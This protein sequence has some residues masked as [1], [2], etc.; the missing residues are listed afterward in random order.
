MPKKIIIFFCVSAVFLIFTALGLI[1]Y[2]KIKEIRNMKD[3]PV[4][5]YE[6]FRESIAKEDYNTALECISDKYDYR[7]AFRNKDK[8]K[9]W[10]KNLPE[11]IDSLVVRGNKAEYAGDMRV[12]RFVRNNQG[13]WEIEQF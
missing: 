1:F 6:R 7:E 2:I 8:L 9:Y 11:N 3:T 5:V 10:A 13:F 4:Q 12:I